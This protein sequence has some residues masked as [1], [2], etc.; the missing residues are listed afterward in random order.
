MPREHA[1]G[2]DT[3]GPLSRMRRSIRT[4]VPC[5]RRDQEAMFPSSTSMRTLGS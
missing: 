4:S 3:A 1:A 5:E 2:S